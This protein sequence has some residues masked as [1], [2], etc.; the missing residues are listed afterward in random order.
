MGAR[1]FYLPL[2][3]SLCSD[4]F[5]IYM[6]RISFHT[7]IWKFRCYFLWPLHILSPHSNSQA[8]VVFFL[9]IW[10]IS[11]ASHTA[12]SFTRCKLCSF[13]CLRFRRSRANSR[14]LILRFL[15]FLFLFYILCTEFR[16]FLKYNLNTF[17][18]MARIVLNL[19]ISRR[20][21]LGISLLRH[22]I[23]TY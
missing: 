2:V 9:C 20:R 10:Y 5:Y 21:S 12:N 19:G 15:I 16:Y 11:L 4:L 14:S 22:R 17:W 7:T 13:I 3:C 18:D 8:T 1:D 6:F 23:G